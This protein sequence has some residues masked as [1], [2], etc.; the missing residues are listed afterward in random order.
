[1]LNVKFRNSLSVFIILL[2]TFKYY[3]SFMGINYLSKFV[4]LISLA[5]SA[6]LISTDYKKYNFLHWF[7]IYFA[8]YD[9][10]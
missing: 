6:V 3:A 1:M 8:K 4:M 9:I 2:A 7:G 10:T 5:V